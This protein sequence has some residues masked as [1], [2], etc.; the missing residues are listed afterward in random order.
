M[1]L[2][3]SPS[4]R[5]KMNK[6]LLII[7]LLLPLCCGC[8]ELRARDEANAGKDALLECNFES[9]FIHFSNAHDIMDHNNDINIG[10][11]A[12]ELLLTLNSNDFKNLF[13]AFGF[14]QSIQ[15]FCL[16]NINSHQDQY[17]S[18]DQ[19][20]D[21]C[22]SGISSNIQLPH[23]CSESVHCD[24]FEYIDPKLE[25]KDIFEAISTHVQNFEHISD[26]FAETADQ[27]REP[28]TIRDIFGF[29]ELYIHPADLYF[30]AAIFELSMFVTSVA[31][32]YK[33]SF[34]VAKSLQT[35]DCQ[36]YAEYINQNMGISDHPIEVSPYI[37][38]L[39][40]SFKHLN[41]AFTQAQK[42]LKDTLERTDA[43]PPKV[44]ILQWS[45]VPY[46]VTDDILSLAS[47]FA[48]EPH[49]IKDIISPNITLDL[50]TLSFPARQPQDA[51]ASCPNDHIHIDYSIYIQA[52]NDCTSPDLLSNN[53]DQIELSPGLSYRLSSGWRRWTPAD[54]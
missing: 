3:K 53:R 38:M 28:Y 1:A 2:P 6:A 4:A 39:R 15:D 23:T 54:L 33:T 29:S 8:E 18:Q 52:I 17:H 16:Q 24:R 5:H 7:L 43:C 12:S 32:Q 22:S 14:T 10:L 30:F 27:L 46:G 49:I 21:S 47:S 34:S 11:A 50:N 35:E 25:W 51:L 48:T 19:N 9:A 45:E 37:N 26:L 44:S 40:K 42:I 13:Q 41:S 31:S 36:T 20:I